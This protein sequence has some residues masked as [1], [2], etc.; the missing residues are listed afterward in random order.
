MPVDEVSNTL[1][2][3]VRKKTLF[4][5]SIRHEGGPAVDPPLRVGVCAAVI[6]NPYAGRYV[7][8]LMPFMDLLQP[9]G[10]ELARDLLAAL[11]GD[12]SAIQAYGKA[13]IVGSNGEIE[14]AALWHVPGGAGLRQVL[15]TKGFVPSAKML[16]GPGTRLM[17]PLLYVNHTWVRSHY[18]I[19][20]FTI[21]DAPRP[22]EIAVAVAMS[23]GGRI[24][25]RIGGMTVEQAENAASEE[26]KR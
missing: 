9:L 7:E 8:N 2:I 4:I 23:T 10:I 16:G 11:G 15:G 17:I 13:A 22:N 6:R 1:A 12:A 19:A 14:H 3:D 5:E 25:A 18:G 26:T 24:H 21:H 20:E